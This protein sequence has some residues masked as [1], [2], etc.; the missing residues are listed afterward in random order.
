MKPRT[1]FVS[2]VPAARDTFRAAVVRICLTV[3]P[4]GANPVR[5]TP[6]RV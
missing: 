4:P 2:D 3:T 5:P 1:Y 6:R